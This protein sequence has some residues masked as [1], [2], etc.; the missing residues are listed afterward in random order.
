M[1]T[2]SGGIISNQNGYSVTYKVKCEKC[3][4]IDSV[5]TTITLTKGVTE[6]TTKKCSSCGN[7]QIVKMRYVEAGKAKCV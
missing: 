3:E 5:E 4:T 2:I 7:I 6:I 1:V